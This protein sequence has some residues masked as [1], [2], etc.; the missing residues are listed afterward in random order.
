MDIVKDG[1]NQGSLN[2][3]HVENNHVGEDQC[4]HNSSSEVMVVGN[5]FGFISGGDIEIRGGMMLQ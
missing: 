3:L 2:K 1:F 5:N 4:W